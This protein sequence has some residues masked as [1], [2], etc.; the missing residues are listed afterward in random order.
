MREYQVGRSA[1]RAALGALQRDGLIERKQGTG[2]FARTPKATH[3]LV[4]ANGFDRSI[5]SSALRLA[6]R[7][8]SVEELRAPAEVARELGAEPGTPCL[9]VECLTLLDGEPAVVL[10]SYCCDER[11]WDGITEAI[12]P[13]VWTGDWYSVLERGGLRARRRE[14]TVEAVALGELVAPLLQ[15]PAGSPALRFQR[16]LWLGDDEIPEYGFSY[17]RGDL[18]TFDLDAEQ[19]TDELC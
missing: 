19:L 9:S 17:C 13:G 3:K 8:L 2:T 4:Q 15:A 16:R 7:L 18:L 5:A 10:T 12:A 6:S 11:A 1:I 14:A